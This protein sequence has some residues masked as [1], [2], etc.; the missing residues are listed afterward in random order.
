MI[1]RS[2]WTY[3]TAASGGASIGELMLSGG[4]FILK[5]PTQTLHRFRYAGLGAGVGWGARVPKSIRLP[6][7]NLP[8]SGT[9]LSASGATTDYPGRGWVYRCRKP[10]LKPSDFAGMTIYVDAGAGLL[11]AES[12]SGFIAGIDQRAMIPWMF[13]PGL[14]ANAIGASARALVGLRGMSE[15]LIDGVGLGFML[16]SI[17]YTGPS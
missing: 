16:G 6:D 5:D 8:R 2:K 9:S 13:N 14:F 11:V 4:S 17:T 12:F 10:E 7:F 1:E 15:G 3:E